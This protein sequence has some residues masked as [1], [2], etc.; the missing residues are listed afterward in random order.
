[1]VS[2]RHATANEF[3]KDF[4]YFNMITFS[5]DLFS[6]CLFAQNRS[7]GTSSY[8]KEW[9]LVWNNDNDDE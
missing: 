1:M 4:F 6:E 5:N 2:L 8:R 3:A 9:F 7:N